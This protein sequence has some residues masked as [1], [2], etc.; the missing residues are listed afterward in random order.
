MAERDLV[1]IGASAGGIKA[2]KEIVLGLP[3]GLPASVLVVVHTRSDGSGALPD[4]LARQTSL[5]VQYAADG[6]PLTAGRIYVAPGDLHLVVTGQGMRTLRGPRENGFRP[7]IDPLFR[8]AAQVHGDRVIGVILSGALD[9]GSYGLSLV[10][11]HGGIAI[12]QDPDDAEIPSMPLSAL[13]ETPVDAV[14]PAH[15]IAES[16]VGF[17]GQPVAGEGA[18]SMARRKAPVSPA[19]GGETE[20]ARMEELFGPPSGMTCPDCGGALWEVVDGHLV[21]YKCHAG[22]QYAP[23]SLLAGQRDVVENALWSAVRVLEEQAEMRR[24][25]SVRADAAGLAVVSQ[26]FADGAE[27]SQRQAEEIRAVLY[28][29]RERDTP[30]APRPRRVRRRPARKKLTPT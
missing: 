6:E 4:L 12:V 28:G 21:R 20:V 26:G 5:P 25:M 1:V 23:D 27:R 3:A 29:G 14:L 10:K 30:A 13:R 24:R 7:A 16:I 9:D 19:P 11:R 8:S 2:L 22:H 18:S 15:R 17:C